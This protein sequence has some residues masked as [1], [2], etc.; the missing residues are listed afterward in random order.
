MTRGWGRGGTCRGMWRESV[1]EI[2]I[3]W[4]R[5]RKCG[6][7][8]DAGHVGTSVVQCLYDSVMLDMLAPQ[9]CSVFT[10]M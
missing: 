5:N 6:R 2:F 9:L 1:P 3:Q 8:C 7:F 4:Y 10:I